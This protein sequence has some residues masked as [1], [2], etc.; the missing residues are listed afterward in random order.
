MGEEM[1]GEGRRDEQST[2]ITSDW[3]PHKTNWG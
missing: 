1:G 2:D 3:Q